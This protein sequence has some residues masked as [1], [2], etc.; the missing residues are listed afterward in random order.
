L[1]WVECPRDAWQGL[2]GFIPTERKVEFLTSLLYAGFRSLDCGSFVS[3]KAVPQM[4]DTEAVLAALPAVEGADYLCIVANE[5]GLERAL[6]SERVTSVGYPLSLSDTFQ[7]RNSGRSLDE[8]WRLVQ[9]LL[10]EASGKRLVVYLS[11]GF[12]NPYGDPWSP[13]AV[14]EAVERLRGIGVREV[15]LADTLGQANAT[16]VTTVVG[17]VVERFGP[18]DLGVHLHSR[19]ENARALALAAVDAGVTWLEG[20]LGGTGG[21]PFAAD[22]LVGNLPTEVVL[23][24]LSERGLDAGVESRDLDRVALEAAA[25][26][27]EFG[28][29]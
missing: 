22:E 5:R 7:S 12:G 29:A 19:P 27:R 18:A 21:C 2:P 17:A 10:A 20:A 13:E 28:T 6:A 14:V 23:P 24:A 9:H 25:I 11:M 26:A 16:R 8:S 1:R 3:A 15:A 4:A